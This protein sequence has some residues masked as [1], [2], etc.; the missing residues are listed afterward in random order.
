MIG[1]LTFSRCYNYGAF[2]QAYALH[3]FL[4]DNGYDNELIDYRSKKSIDNELNSLLNERK[5]YTFLTLKI[6]FKIL[7]FKIYH[8]KFK[9]TKH[10]FSRE[11]LSQK[12]YDLIIIGSDQIWC[13]SKEWGGVDT[14]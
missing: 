4:I 7:K 6:W 5:G 9:K 3:R 8:F 14:P 11:E 13:Y 10:Y 2:L 1:I 12:H